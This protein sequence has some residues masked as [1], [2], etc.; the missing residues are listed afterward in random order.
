[1]TILRIANTIVGMTDDLT[2]EATYE[3]VRAE[4]WLSR[5]GGAGVSRRNLL[6]ASAGIGLGAAMA[7]TGQ[8]VG[9]TA[10]AA[11]G[12]PGHSPRRARS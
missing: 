11:T 6:R 1:L 5:V 3:R 7:G 8:A 4:Q 9:G 2:D 10:H 12:S